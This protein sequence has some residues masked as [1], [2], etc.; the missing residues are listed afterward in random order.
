MPFYDINFNRV[1]VTVTRPDEVERVHAVLRDRLNTVHVPT[2][3]EDGRMSIGIDQATAQESAEVI[4]T[5]V[6]REFSDSE[7][8]IAVEARVGADQR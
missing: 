6:A 1:L 2:P 8:W 7:A 5:I 3:D 4:R